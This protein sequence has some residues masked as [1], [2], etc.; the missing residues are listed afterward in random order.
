[1][2]PLFLLM[3][4]FVGVGFGIWH[5]NEDRASEAA[6]AQVMQEAFEERSIPRGKS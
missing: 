3:T 4:L 2:K 6:Q 5:L 1:M